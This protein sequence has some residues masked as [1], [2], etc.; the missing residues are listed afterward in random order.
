MGERLL[1]DSPVQRTW[2]TTRNADFAFNPVFACLTT[3]SN[4]EAEHLSAKVSQSIRCSVWFAAVT[5][6]RV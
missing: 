1:A 2:R 5:V 6:M 4:E 3:F